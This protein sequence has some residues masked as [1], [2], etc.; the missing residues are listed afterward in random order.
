MSVNNLGEQVAL[1]LG[2][3]AG[4]CGVSGSGKST[5]IV[6]TLGRALAPKKQTTSVAHVPVDPGEHDAIQGAPSRALLIDQSRAGV[7]SPAAFLDLLLP[8]GLFMPVKMPGA[9][10]HRRTAY[11]KWFVRRKRCVCI[12]MGFCRCP[13]AKPAAPATHSVKCICA[14]SPLPEVYSLTIDQTYALFGDDE[15]LSRPLQA[16]HT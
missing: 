16:A 5:L 9:G 15:R 14:G 11:D 10:D 3:L 6:D 2:V 1:P 8:A 7:H 4:V 13:R 12:D